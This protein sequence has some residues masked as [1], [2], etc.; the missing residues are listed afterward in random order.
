MTRR[1]ITKTTENYTPIH[2]TFK[3]IVGNMILASANPQGFQQGL[4]ER[5]FIEMMTQVHTW[6]NEKQGR[7]IH[8]I[9]NGNKFNYMFFENGKK[10]TPAFSF[11]HELTW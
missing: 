5:T 4:R 7:E 1:K 3:R 11:T 2:P 8:I 10:C 9:N 6:L